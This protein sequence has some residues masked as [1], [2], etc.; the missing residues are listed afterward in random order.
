[1]LKKKKWIISAIIVIVVLILM[2]VLLLL[3]PLFVD[4]NNP[5]S[6]VSPIPSE[7]KYGF[8]L[9]SFYVE[10]GV[11][12]KNE[13]LSNILQKHDVSLG[14]IDQIAKKSVPIFDVRKIRSGKRYTILKTN[15][16][17]AIAQYFI[18]ENDA[19]HYT[20]FQL[21]DSLKIYQEYHEITI[22]Q[23]TLSGIITSS[24]WKAIIDNGG[25]PDLAVR[26]SDVYEWT[27]DFFA[28]QKNDAFHVIYDKKLINEQFVGTGNIQAALFCHENK[29]YYAFYYQQDTTVS[30]EYY[31]ENGQSLR[32]QFLKAPLQYSR[33]SSTFS[34][35][36]MHPVL[37][38]RRPHHGVDYAAPAGTPVRSIGKGKVIEKAY[39]KNG[40]GNYLKIKHNNVYTTVYMH[41]QG[42][43]KGIAVGSSVS[44][45]QIIGY[46][47]STGIA[48]GPH[49]DFR[50]FKNGSAINPLKMESP[51]ATPVAKSLMSQYLQQITPLKSALEE[52]NK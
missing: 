44:Q 40:G 24:L 51:P 47:G 16:T 27:I 28:I 15:D 32:R 8:V 42:Y 22:V 52:K 19:E 17:L 29:N 26:L 7:I 6:N 34:N 10:E 21:F 43:A 20:V 41:L 33:I 1:M 9:D 5:F 14:V 12:Q 3:R 35:S 11:V 23:D 13:N 4:V 39:Q 25:N 37:R 38:I 48:T 30:G 31:D 18:Y 36:R 50:V 46:V 2:V 49:L 45:G